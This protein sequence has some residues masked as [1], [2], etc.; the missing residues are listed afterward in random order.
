MIEDFLTQF[1]LL[2]LHTSV[3]PI[4]L[5]SCIQ[6]ETKFHMG[7]ITFYVKVHFILPLI[8]VQSETLLLLILNFLLSTNLNFY[9]SLLITLIN[10]ELRLKS[11][12]CYS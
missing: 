2:Y 8:T 5:R 12:D 9:K 7:F 4:V 6:H 3:I 1:S 10:N 11:F